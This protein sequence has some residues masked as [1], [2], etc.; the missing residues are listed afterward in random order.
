MK[1]SKIVLHDDNFSSSSSV[2]SKMANYWRNSSHNNEIDMTKNMIKWNSECF[3]DELKFVNYINLRFLLKLV[4]LCISIALIAFI[5]TSSILNTNTPISNKNNY[6]RNNSDIDTKIIGDH[7]KR[8]RLLININKTINNSEMNSNSVILDDTATKASITTIT[9]TTPPPSS[10]TSTLKSTS[11]KLPAIATATSSSLIF[12]VEMTM[13]DVEKDHGIK[14]IHHAVDISQPS[15]VLPRLT[16][17]TTTS[18]IKNNNNVI[19]QND[20]HAKKSNDE[21]TKLAKNYV[22]QISIIT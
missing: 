20:E 9:T 14:S 7:P 19:V 10:L 22:R 11:S 3:R 6:N 16:T 13:S 17:T 4:T 2:A 12:N 18:Y 21:V 1:P 5:V 15:S 8:Q